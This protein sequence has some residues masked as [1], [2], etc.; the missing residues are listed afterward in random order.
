MTAGGVAIPGRPS[1]LSGRIAVFLSSSTKQ[2]DGSQRGEVI[3]MRIKRFLGSLSGLYVAGALL[4]LLTLANC[5]PAI[6]DKAPAIGSE[7]PPF[8]LKDVAG[9][10]HTLEQYKGK[11]V[12]LD[13]CS[14]KCPW[15]RGAD[16]TLKDVA[17]EYAG[18]GVVFLGVDS[19]KSTP[20]EEIKEY[21][22]ESILNS[23]KVKTMQ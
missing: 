17:K 10:E 8:Q 6:A 14:Q 22:E 20:P 12:V 18:K 7:M 13:F 2:T 15:S 19:H 4:L 23:L 5:A 3:T 9:K 21:L 11:I 16:K 1:G